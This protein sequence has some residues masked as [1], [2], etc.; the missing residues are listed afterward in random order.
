MTGKS[1]IGPYLVIVG[2]VGTMLCTGN[3]K[4]ANSSFREWRDI[5]KSGAGRAA[6]EIVTL[7]DEGG[8]E[9]LR[10]YYPKQSHGSN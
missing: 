9:I 3:F 5:S 10:E 1:G 6:G 7:F 8:Q 2:N 4:Q